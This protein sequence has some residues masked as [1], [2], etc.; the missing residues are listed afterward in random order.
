M[1]VRITNLRR[2]VE[3]RRHSQRMCTSS[4]ESIRNLKKQLLFCDEH[5]AWSNPR[6]PDAAPYV[7]TL[8]RLQPSQSNPYE[9]L[10]GSRAFQLGRCSE[11]HSALLRTKSRVVPN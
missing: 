9:R 1:T 7:K 8:H 4:E 6:K 5:V 11:V 2:G 10:D 3:A